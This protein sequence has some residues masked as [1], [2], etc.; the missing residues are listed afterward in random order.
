ML[1]DTLVYGPYT[2]RELEVVLAHELGHLSRNHIWKAIGWYALF[3]FPG[4]YLLA[5]FTR[6]RGGM[7]VPDAIPL[8]IFALVVLQL[9]QLPLQ[10]VISRHLEAEADWSALRATHDPTGGRQLFQLFASETLE[11]PSPPWWD[12]VFLENHP[13]PLQRIEMTRYYERYYA[14]RT[15]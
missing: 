11:D 6:P 7:G 8:A 1:W 4:A 5:L 10:N 2:Y 14:R 15:P 13:T 9:V 12:Y 3:A